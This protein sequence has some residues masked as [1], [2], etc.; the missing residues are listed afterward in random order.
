MAKLILVYYVP[1]KCSYAGIPPWTPKKK[2]SRLA[3]GFSRSRDFGVSAEFV[4]NRTL[5]IQAQSRAWISRQSVERPARAGGLEFVPLARDVLVARGDTGIA[6]D[7]WH[8][9]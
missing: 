5:S 6:D 4:L 9:D 8:G 2:Q 7:R 1:S 3:P